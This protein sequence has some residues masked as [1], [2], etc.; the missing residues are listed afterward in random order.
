MQRA[1]VRTSA[2][3]PKLP[4]SRQVSQ[5]PRRWQTKVVSVPTTSAQHPPALLSCMYCPAQAGCALRSLPG[6]LGRHAVRVAPPPS[7]Q[8]QP[9]S[10]SSSEEASLCT[11]APSDI[12]YDAIIIG[13]GMGGLTTAA[14][15][16]SKGAKVLVLEK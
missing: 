6:Q 4:F 2:C 12:E 16:V 5:L 15:M 1:S 13:S 14:Q 8:A 9:A 11:D 3:L 7:A 10:S